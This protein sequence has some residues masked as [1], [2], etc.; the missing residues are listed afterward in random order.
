MALSE[1]RTKNLME[2]IK[3]QSQRGYTIDRK[4][5]ANNELS[6]CCLWTPHRYNKKKNLCY[7]W[8]KNRHKTKQK[9]F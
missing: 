3:A 2:R 5:H 6:S 1:K 9:T 7:M 4:A 8:A